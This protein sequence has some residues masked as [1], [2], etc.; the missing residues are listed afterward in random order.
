MLVLVTRYSL[1][2]PCTYLQDFLLSFHVV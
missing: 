2:N 1:L